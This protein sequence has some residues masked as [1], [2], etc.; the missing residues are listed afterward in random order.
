MEN[1]KMKIY[2]FMINIL[3]DYKKRSI[4]VVRNRK[5]DKY[6]L[7]EKRGM[8]RGKDY[9][10][11]LEPH[12]FGSNGRAHRIRG[13]IIDRSYSFMSDGEVRC[14]M[15]MQM[16]K[17]VVDIREQYPLL[18]LALTEVIA[19][20][21]GVSHPPKNKKKKTVMTTDLVVT[22]F[23]KEKGLYEVAIAV[24]TKEQLKNP[25]TLE[26]L[27]LEE[28]YWK[29]L[30]VKFVVVTEEDL[31]QKMAINLTFI[32]RQYFWKEENGLTD[33]FV[34]E[35]VATLKDKLKEQDKRLSDILQEI[36]KQYELE[37]G[38]GPNFIYYLI[39]HQKIEVNLSETLSLNKLQIKFNEVQ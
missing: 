10:P 3:N 12:E 34:E 22:F 37:E 1:D 11:W 26:K 2:E 36:E 20:E 18:P 14:F 35:L 19:E 4:I 13:W 38:E 9:R 30:G 6:R 15:L 39:T 29:R 33:E 25:R 16:K 8:G 28:E 24:K 23:D 21:I 32:Y 5:S 7:K 27:S 31:D 17:G